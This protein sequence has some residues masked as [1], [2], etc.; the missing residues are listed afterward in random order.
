VGRR[1]SDV[2]EDLCDLL[3]DQLQTSCFALQINEATDV[4]ERA[5]LIIHVQFVLEST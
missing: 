4:V 2:S 5:N 1:I 3:I